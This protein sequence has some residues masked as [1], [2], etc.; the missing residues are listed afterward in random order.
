M[1][2]V[3]QKPVFLKELPIFNALANISKRLRKFIPKPQLKFPVLDYQ[4]ILFRFLETMRSFNW[5]NVAV[6]P[7]R[8]FKFLKFHEKICLFMIHKHCLKANGYYFVLI[9]FEIH[10]WSEFST[11]IWTL[12][13]KKF[14]FSE[15]PNRTSYH[16]NFHTKKHHLYVW[17][18]IFSVFHL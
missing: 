8:N 7:D 17:I 11:L 2:L 1:M 5:T 10:H 9:T 12:N 18:G 16:S 14:S 6:L 13:E 15:Y 3:T 4:D